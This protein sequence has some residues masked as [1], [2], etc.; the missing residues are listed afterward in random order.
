[1]GKEDNFGDKINSAGFD[2][3][4]QNI[5]NKKPSIKNQLK[6]LLEKDGALNIPAKSVLKINDDGSV[7]IKLPTEMQLAMK[8]KQWAMSKKGNDSLKAIQMI[9]EQI[10]GK[11]KQEVDTNIKTESIDTWL[12]K[13]KK[14]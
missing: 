9:M 8:L 2:K 11:P 7:T 14:T 10:D 12:S 3:N 5:G 6:E 13:F 1:M 4:P